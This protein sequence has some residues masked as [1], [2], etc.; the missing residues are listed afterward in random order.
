LS[1]VETVYFHIGLEFSKQVV[2]GEYPVLVPPDQVDLGADLSHPDLELAPHLVHVLLHLLDCGLLE[3][4][5]SD[6]LE[7]VDIHLLRVHLSELL[8]QLKAH[9][10][11]DP[12]GQLCLDFLLLGCLGPQ[13]ALKVSE[14]LDD[15][16]VRDREALHHKV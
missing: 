9:L 5:F 4:A 2:D 10:L 14:V 1:R 6:P 7:P 16:L 15:L 3:L 11:P 13:P 8:P 12:G